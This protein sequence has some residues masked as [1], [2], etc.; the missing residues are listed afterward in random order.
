MAST[1]RPQPHPRPLQS[2]QPSKRLGNDAHHLRSLPSL[3]H[4]IR[5]RQPF[6]LQVVQRELSQRVQ[7]HF[8]RLLPDYYVQLVNLMVVIKGNHVISIRLRL[9]FFQLPIRYRHWDR[10]LG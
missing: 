7:A 8:F 10:I 6:P 1:E 2:I 9:L 3:C 5:M 4:F